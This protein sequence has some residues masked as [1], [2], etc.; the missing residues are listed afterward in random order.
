M[1]DMDLEKRLKSFV[2]SG[3]YRTIHIEENGTLKNY[4]SAQPVTDDLPTLDFLKDKINEALFLADAMESITIW[5]F[6]DC[7]KYS[8]VFMWYLGLVNAIY[9]D[10]YKKQPRP[11]CKIKLNSPA[12]VLQSARTTSGNKSIWIYDNG[13]YIV[14]DNNS[15]KDITD[16]VRR[17]STARQLTTEQPEKKP[18]MQLHISHVAKCQTI[19]E[20]F[21]LIEKALECRQ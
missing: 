8:D 1:K 13:N 18:V 11:E 16:V 20:L 3:K 14:H 6:Y 4:I 5:Q 9:L 21:A 2:Q 10:G 17:Y 19:D 12:D 7:L 15:T